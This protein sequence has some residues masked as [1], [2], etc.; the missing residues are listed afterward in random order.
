VFPIVLWEMGLALEEFVFLIMLM[1]HLFEHI[2][3]L[4]Q[5]WELIMNDVEVSGRLESKV[6]ACT[7][8]EQMP[9]RRDSW[10]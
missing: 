2:V 1:F 3:V 8:L 5:T 6:G 7:K 9:L 10:A 4:A